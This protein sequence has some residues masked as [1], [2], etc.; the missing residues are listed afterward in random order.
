M[1]IKVLVTGASGVLGTA[2]FNAFKQSNKNFEVKGLAHSRPT[3]ELDTL[4]LLDE[5]A[6]TSYVDMLQPDWIIHCAAERRPDA[7][8]ANPEGSRKLNATV[9]SFLARLSARPSPSHHP[10]TLIY[11]STD[12]VFDGT[13]APYD[14]D[15]KPKPINVYGE[16]KRAGEVGVLEIESD[17]GQRVV[18]R[19]PVLY[20]PCPKP[21]DTAINIL[22]EIVRDQ[23]GKNY[24]MDH[25]GTR[26]PTN[27]LDIASFLIRLSLLDKPLPPILHYTGIEPYT[28]Y[29]ICLV[30]AN[31]LSVPHTHITPD[32]SVPSPEAA[33][34]R[35]KDCQLSMR[36]LERLGVDVGGHGFEEWWTEYLNP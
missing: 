34:S 21:S 36:V 16:T 33:A 29:E 7:V 20:G 4:D 5:A 10:F 1:R 9:P 22:E 31:I 17:Q 15:D 6:V 25:Y 13:S 18:L 23:T 32:A 27:V 24:T 2:I 26:Y 35:P 19:V 11:I 30:L 3:D 14:V 12:Y 8:A 28:K